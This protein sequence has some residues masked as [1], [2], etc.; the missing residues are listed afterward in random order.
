MPRKRTDREKITVRID[1]SVILEARKIARRDYGNESRI[2]PVVEDA[3]TKYVAAELDEGTIK[4][5]FSATEGALYNRISRK[6]EKEIDGFV[7]R[8]GN[9]IASQSY[10]TTLATKM[11]EDWFFSSRPNAKEKYEDMRSAAQRR[12]KGRFIR[13]GADP[14]EINQI[15]QV[16]SLKAENEKLREELQESIDK[17]QKLGKRLRETT[18]QANKK[19][20]FSNEYIRWSN[21]LINHLLENQSITKSN[22]KLYQEYV[23]NH[24]KPE[25]RG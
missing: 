19:I 20:D 13:N 17:C 1:P 11:I 7:T 3:L 24:P 25:E 14:S 18:E 9:L 22:K 8:V 23:S 21:G 16:E 5:I 6:I 2:S 10:E 4:A 12:L 15:D